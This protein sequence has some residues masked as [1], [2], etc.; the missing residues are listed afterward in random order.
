MRVPHVSALP[1]CDLAGGPQPW[2]TA[3]TSL[4][5]T[6][7]LAKASK[8]AWDAYPIDESGRNQLFGELPAGLAGGGK[9]GA[10]AVD[11][12]ATT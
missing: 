5:F 7:S 6:F 4:L 2:R 12:D 8:N 11:L 10:A 9:A 1:P 3:L